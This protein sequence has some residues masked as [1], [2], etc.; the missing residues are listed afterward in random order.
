MSIYTEE[1]FHNIQ[2]SQFN[3]TPF[4]LLYNSSVYCLQTMQISKRTFNSNTLI[5]KKIKIN[6]R[7]IVKHLY[8]CLGKC[9]AMKYK[10]TPA[11]S[12]N[13][14]KNMACTIYYFAYQ[15]IIFCFTIYFPFEMGYKNDWLKQK[16]NILFF[17]LILLRHEYY[18]GYCSFWKDNNIYY[19]HISTKC[20][21]TST[22]LTDRNKTMP[23][24][25]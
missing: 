24:I 23:I 13:G 2:Q 17:C 7:F 1:C 21:V 22:G 20:I 18:S 25:C 11:F 14:C 3:S 6:I 16:T 15:V 19:L 10:R 12:F 4:C 5:D 9:C 8:V